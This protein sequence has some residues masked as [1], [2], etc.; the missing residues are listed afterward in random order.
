MTLMTLI[1]ILLVQAAGTAIGALVLILSDDI[2]PSQRRPEWVR[3]LQAGL[4]TAGAI[5]LF[6]FITS[7]WL[8]EL[9]RT[10]SNT[11]VF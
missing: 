10:M 1:S 2:Y 6:F 11:E 9:A 3:W 4:W 8:N 7:D 5:A